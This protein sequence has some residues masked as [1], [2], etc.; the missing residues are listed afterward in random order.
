MF[1]YWLLFAIFALGAVAAR[2]TVPANGPANSRP[3]LRHGPLLAIA[4]LVPVAM[5]GFRYEVGGD[6]SA[7]D[8]IFEEIRYMGFWEAM[9]YQEPA[10]AALNWFAQR[11]DI[12][13]W[14]V[15]LVCGAIFTAGLVSFARTQPNPWLAVLVAVP[16][17]VIGVAMGYSRQGV[18]IG[19]LMFGLTAISNNSFRKFVFWIMLAAMFH[20]TAIVML[21]IVG[22]SYTRNRIQSVSLAI[23]GVAVAYFAMIAPALDR[24]TV[25][26]IDFV[27]ESEGAIVRLAMNLVPASLFLFLGNRFG[28]EGAEKATWRSFALLAF[29]CIVANIFVASSVIT[30]RLALYVIPLQIFVFSRLPHA[31]GHRGKPSGIIVILL[32]AYSAIVQFVW[33]NYANHAQYWLPYRLYPL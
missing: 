18:A 2:R 1:P 7:Y 19:C 20:R 21:P 12:E 32:V 25:G 11:L 31:L 13:I 33:L 6:W 4:A 17:L 10:Y 29:G 14:A 28:V 23:A 22:L 26:Y 24:Y 5:I 9:S 3:P 27:Y 16:F 30:D 8:F 15:N